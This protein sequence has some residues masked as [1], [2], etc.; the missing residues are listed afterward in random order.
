MEFTPYTMLTDIGWI[1]VLLIIGNVLRNR[2]KVLQALLLPA[3]IT[4]G[5]IGLVLGQEVLGV[6]SWSDSVG[7]YTTLLIAVVFASMAYSM[8]LGGSVAAGARNMWAYTTSMFMGQWGLFI[9][10]GL[11]LFAPLFGTEPWFGMMLPVG[12]VGGFG[13][14]AAVGSALEGVGVENASSIGF[15]SATVGTLVAIVGGVI[16]AN[17]GI[18]KGKAAELSGDLPRELRTGYIDDESERPSIGKATT[19]P[20]SIEPLALHGG[21][22][23][24]TVLIAYMLNQLVKSQW[25]NVS[26]PLFAMACVVGLIGRGLLKAVGRPNYLD[27]DTIS[28]IS[29]AATD[30]MIA[31]GIASIVPAALAGYWQAL[32]LLFVLGTVFCVV[33]MLWAGPLFFGTNWLER[34]LFGWGWATAAVATGIA[35]LKMVDPKLKSGTLNEYGVAYVGFA[36]FEIGMTI[37]APIAVIAGFVT[38]LGWIAFAVA[39]GVVIL[40][41]ASKWV[42]AKRE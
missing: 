38:G 4:A 42:P 10:L 27:R 5:L 3:P 24:F 13:T 29:G 8:E 23:V 41:F 21:F 37:L 32:L 7:T 6:I 9:L 11:Y 40:S 28:S 15:T 12:F 39:V 25:E 34:G 2:L 33:W 35:L 19:N 17:W 26:I 20:S 36:P 30:Y 31:F 14:A 1:S 22:V 16:V 18:R